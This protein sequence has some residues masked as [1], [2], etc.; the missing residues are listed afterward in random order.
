[1]HIAQVSNRQPAE[2]DDDNYEKLYEKMYGISRKWARYQLSL[3]GRMTIAKTFLLPQFTYIALV[4]DPSDKSYKTINNFIRNFVNTSTTRPSISK[5][6]I[7]QDILYGPR[8]EGGLD[9]IDA[10][11]FFL[12]H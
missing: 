4:L 10:C 6:W 1:M 8:N 2:Q 9:F 5:N 7:N 12:P 3:K 11:S